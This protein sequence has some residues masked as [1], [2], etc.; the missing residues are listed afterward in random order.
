MASG[1]AYAAAERASVSERVSPDAVEVEVGERD[2]DIEAVA[3]LFDNHT[4]NIRLC[5]QELYHRTTPNT[6]CRVC[7][8]LV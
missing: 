3:P 2:D 1:Q 4:Y 5:V 6:N 7:K 8:L